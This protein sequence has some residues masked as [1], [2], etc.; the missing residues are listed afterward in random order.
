[1]IA[2][3][4]FGWSVGELAV[5]ATL[6]GLATVLAVAGLIAAWL[7]AQSRVTLAAA[8]ATAAPGEEERRR[9]VFWRL[10]LVFFLAASAR[11]VVL[12]QAAGIIT[13]YCGADSLALFR[14]TLISR[15]IV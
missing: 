4:V 14:P 11:V 1:M 6:A 2:A 13:A 3:L 10:W 7:I 9:A 12:S 8:A 15:H 5:R